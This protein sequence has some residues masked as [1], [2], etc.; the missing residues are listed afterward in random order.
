MTVS[1]G[2]DIGTNSVGSA[3]VD[4]D[5]MLVRPAVSVFP[6]GVEEK[7]EGRGAPKNQQRRQK[8]SL[9]RSLARRSAR[10]R[11][12]RAFLVKV[13]L[14][15][16]E[17][18]AMQE[19][20]AQ[21]PWQLRRRALDEPITPFQFG[22]ILL[23]MAQRRGALGIVFDE[24]SEEKPDQST[25]NAAKAD[26]EGAVKKAIGETRRAMEEQKS[27]TFGE[28]MAQRAQTLRVAVSPDPGRRRC[29]RKRPGA[30]A[31]SVP[32][33]IRNK[34]G[35]FLF[36]ADR[37]MLRD[38]FGQIWAAQRQLS[39]DLAAL[40]TDEVRVKL[41]H[42]RKT[43]VWRHQGLLFGQRNTY[44]RT[45]TLGR[46]SLEP[47]DQCV[48]IADRHAS[49]FRVVETVNN[50]RLRGPQ[51]ASFL[52]LDARQRAQVIE[53]LRSQ[54]TATVKTIRA[55]LGIDKRSLRRSRSHEGHF[56]LN[57]ERD[58]EREINTDWFHRTIVLAGVGLEIWN[59]WGESR[60][61][62]L[63]QA[64]LRFDPASDH[65]ASALRRVLAKLGLPQPAAENVVKGWHARPKLEARLKLSR[66]AVC[67]LLPYMEAPLQDGRWRTQIE[68]RQ[69]FANDPNARD[70]V[71]NAP[72]S[73]LQRRRYALGFTALRKRDR[74]YL[75]KHPE[76]FVPPAP[77]LTNPVVR[78]AIHEVRRHII[79]HLRA[80]GGRKPDR[81]VIE[82]A[83][84]ARR[85]AKA[86]DEILARNRRRQQIR[87]RIREEVI[88]PELGPEYRSWTASKLRAAE[89]RVILCRQQKCLCAYSGRSLT[90]SQAARGND[91]EID[92]IIPYSRCGDNSLNNRVLCYLDANRDK[93]NLTPREWWGQA[94]DERIAPLR[95]MDGYTPDSKDYFSKR[96]YAAKWSKLTVENWSDEWKPSQLT[97]TAYAAR[98]VQAYI[99]QA[100]W[101]DEPM[102]LAEGGNRRVFVTRGGYTALLRRDWQLYETDSANRARGEE[103]ALQIG[104]KDRGDHREH[105]VDAVV[106]ALTDPS[107]M[108]RLAQIE[109]Q[110]DID[111]ATARNQ[112]CSASLG[113][114]EPLPPPWG[115]TDSFRRYVLRMIYG[116]FGTSA[117][118][119]TAGGTRGLVVCHRPSGNRLRT[120]LHEETLFGPIAENSNLF[121]GHVAV[122]DLTPKHL[123]RPEPETDEFA[124][125]RLTD[126]L[127]ARRPA[128]TL[129]DARREAKKIVECPGFIRKLVEPAPAKSGLVR[130]VGL[131]KALRE[132]LETRFAELGIDA[133]AD[134]FKPPDLLR[135]L[136]DP[137]SGAARPLTLK[138]GVPVR[139]VAVLRTM[140]DPVLI[141]R[142]VWNDRA[143]KWE[144]QGD[145]RSKRA[146]VG[147][148]NHHIEIR[149]H[150]G[151]WSGHVVSAYEANR[152][153]R[154]GKAAIDR[155]ADSEGG[156]FV[157]SLAEGDIVFMRDRSQ[158]EVADYFVVFKLDKPATIHF[159]RHDDAR[160]ATGTKDESGGVIPG[161]RREDF[162][163]SA[164]Q[165]KQLAPPGEA[166]PV[167]VYVDVLGN[168]RPLEPRLVENTTEQSIDPRIIALAKEALL[169]RASR[170]NDDRLTSKQRAAGSW[171]WMR[172]RLAAMGLADRGA[173]LSRAMKLEAAAL[174]SQID[175]P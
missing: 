129:A 69:A 34:H 170:E 136:K 135:A 55:V 23:H 153:L 100:L 167:K 109:R 64:I 1:L 40:L 128:G 65:D 124:I 39:N 83:R 30:P 134:N 26:D 10:K 148:N 157:M 80:S 126:R 28:F 141:P 168:V 120:R 25:A 63:N 24:E 155:S 151:H 77:A 42:P 3:W 118:A 14:L 43:L 62:G 56:A 156:R 50:I 117:A 4:T 74:Y 163:V 127:L 67:N 114:R 101:P 111:R 58:V 106:I 139:R 93:A 81:V 160:R 88:E 12:L 57:L 149:V 131:R 105:A 158:R 61:E 82:F 72:A 49:Y 123:R 37:E 132:A 20:L 140:N 33:P 36:H 171:S 145:T 2:L 22:R 165:L 52:P 66:R 32:V 103:P 152:R 159:K 76:K 173:E 73:E 51:S 21:D 70:A 60:R 5:A 107:L 96:D 17:S 48:P 172:S 137:A 15:P 150:G 53:K 38:E 122:A 8:R 44:W 108:Q 16:S 54:K 97:D 162:K 75:R 86:N 174:Q 84:E 85:S 166:A 79:A 143:L 71:S 113:K 29:H 92:H 104:A 142:K 6:A 19:L 41:D 13:G 146:Y 11:H 47:T 59:N 112:G 31:T 91:L 164:A 90:E 78:K 95:F 130:D 119:S 138:S 98:E 115:T 87:R 94:F 169:A 45:G 7:E 121:I 102:H 147:G 99:Q 9:R 125:K 27:R 133:N 144:V 161:S 116:A 46:C 110:R 35:E 154:A 18:A 175:S 68:A 89:E